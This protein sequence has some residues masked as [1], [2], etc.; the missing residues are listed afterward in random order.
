M[1]EFNALKNVLFDKLYMKN[2]GKVKKTMGMEVHYD[3]NEKEI[4]IIQTTA[5]CLLQ[6][7][8]C[9]AECKAMNTEI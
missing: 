6:Q 2:L 8:F 5:V 3:R 1:K 4:K 9:I 7:D